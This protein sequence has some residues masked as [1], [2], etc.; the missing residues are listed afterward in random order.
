MF[1]KDKQDLNKLIEKMKSELE[2][3]DCACKMEA[4]AELD[5]YRSLIRDYE[6][7]AIH[8]QAELNNKDAEL[9]KV[10]C[11][12]AT[13]WDN[14]QELEIHSNEQAKLICELQDLQKG[15]QE[16][17]FFLMSLLLLLSFLL[18]F[19]FF[20]HSRVFHLTPYILSIFILPLSLT[21]IFLY[22]FLLSFTPLFL[23]LDSFFLHESITI[24]LIKIHFPFSFSIFHFFFYLN[25]Y[26]FFLFLP[27][28]L[29]P[30]L[31][32]LNTS[33]LIYL[34]SFFFNFFSFVY[35]FSA[36]HF[37]FFFFFFF[38]VFHILFIPNLP[39]GLCSN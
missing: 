23:C 9:E 4:D 19:S 29:L 32:L 36:S 37:L 15:T 30:L 35:F 33:S 5:Q 13:L 16:A 31:K 25:F 17:H 7:K 26:F 18:S 27:P 3:K 38:F 34:L 39:Q 2:K 20:L 1:L 24:F 21:H 14:N 11:D 8:H 12:L 28:N 6:L 22:L 10:R